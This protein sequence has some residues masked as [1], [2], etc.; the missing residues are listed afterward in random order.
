MHSEATD[1]LVTS[2]RTNT[3]YTSH[4][5]TKTSKYIIDTSITKIFRVLF[6][7]YDTAV[8]MKKHS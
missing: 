4:G 5:N 2:I 7:Y 6:S 3:G 8:T 1:C